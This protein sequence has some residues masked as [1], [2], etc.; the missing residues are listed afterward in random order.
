MESLEQDL[1]TA[2]ATFGQN[3][4]ALAK[5]LEERC[6]LEGEVD[7]IHNVAQL[8]VSEVFG[9]AP[10][11]SAPAIQ[12][13]EVLDEICALIT[14]GL[15]Y[16][17]SGVLTL[18]AMYYPNPDFATICSGHADGLSTE[19]IQTPGESLLPHVRLV[20]EQVSA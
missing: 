9:S 17:A 6:A 18:V 13:A 16:G 7:Q 12:L 2:K 1:E 3:V 11:T 15:F 4:E 19:D 14:H 8:V 5:S 10:S 20:V